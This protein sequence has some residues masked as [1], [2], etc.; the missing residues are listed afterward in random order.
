MYIT[1]FVFQ[2][3]LCAV[4]K[5]VRGELLAVNKYHVTVRMLVTSIT[6]TALSHLLN[7][8]AYEVRLDGAKEGWAEGF[9]VP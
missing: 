7:V 8:A 5:F 4:C 2:I 3:L 1:F 6:A 9:P